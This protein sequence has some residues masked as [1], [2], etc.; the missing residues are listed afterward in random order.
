MIFTPFNIK[1]LHEKTGII[2]GEYCT[3]VWSRNEMRRRFDNGNGK[4]RRDRESGGWSDVINKEE[5]LILGNT[6][7]CKTNVKTVRYGGVV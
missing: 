4:K 7:V 3:R 6:E 5:I 1:E 2:I